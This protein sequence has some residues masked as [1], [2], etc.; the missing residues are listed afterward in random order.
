MRHQLAMMVLLA[1]GASAQE[2]K[3]DFDYLLG[4][5][6]FT[7]ESVD[8]GKF[9]GRWSAVRLTGGQILDEYRVLGGKGETVYS[10]T[11]IRAYN[12]VT[13][14]WELIGM[15]GG[16]GLQDF[17][18]ARKVGDEM[19]IEQRFDVARGKPSSMRIRYYN[20]QADRFSWV[21]DRSKDG[22][23]TWEKGALKI[24]A[25]RTGPARTLPALVPST[26]E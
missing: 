19:H 15:D 18:T 5:W 26:K 12:A 4:D 25:R 23:T 3:A 9:E 8:Y 6:R 10:T 17:G 13:Q 22:G 11:T 7:A 24:E 14:R 16:G 21:G 2:P 1:A 20:I